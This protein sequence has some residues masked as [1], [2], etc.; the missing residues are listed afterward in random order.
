MRPAGAAKDTGRC[1]VCKGVLLPVVDRLFDTR[2]GLSGTYRVA[3]CDSCGLEQTVERPSPRELKRLYETHYNFGGSRDSAYVRLRDHFHFS[4]VYQWWALFDGDIAFCTIRRTGRL[5]DVGCNEGRGLKFYRR[6]GLEAEG[7]ELNERAAEMAR[8]E[9]FVV[10]ACP[11]EEFVPVRSYDIVVLANVLEH[12]LDP[13]EMLRLAGQVLKP[14]G[15]LWVSCPNGSSWLRWLFGGYWI[16]WHVPFHISHFSSPTL[17][18]LLE[19]TGLNIVSLTQETPALWVAHS[20]IARLF[21][22]PERLT[23]HL[24]SPY[25]IGSLILLIRF[26]LFPFLWLGNRLQRGDCLKVIAVRS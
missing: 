7:L 22:R 17:T 5:L 23:Y 21:A 4:G 20:L 18:Q 15:H 24:R 25:L 11:L 2:Y 9:G 26:F 16:N 14:G 1:L 13:R 6:N 3:R 19:S 10:H 8:A 12:S